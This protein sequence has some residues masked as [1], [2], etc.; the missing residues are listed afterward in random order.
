M[1]VGG[2]D[3]DRLLVSIRSVEGDVF[4]EALQDSM[5]ASRADILRA[6][7]HLGC[8][9]GEFRDAIFSELEGDALGAEQADVLTR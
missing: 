9:A 1:D 3:D 7:V 8:N 4:E 5:Q 2:V 6:P